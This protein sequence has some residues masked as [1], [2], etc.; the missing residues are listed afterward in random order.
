MPR[1][2]EVHRAICM[3]ISVNRPSAVRDC[4]PRS[5]MSAASSSASTLLWTNSVRTC[6][7]SKTVRARKGGSGSV[8][9]RICKRLIDCCQNVSR[10][11]CTSNTVANRK[12]PTR[13]ACAQSI[14]KLPDDISNVANTSS[15]KQF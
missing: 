8:S 3:T 10:R 7:D 15:F 5:R 4:W 11:N 14:T 1:V 2:T 13:K 9:M 12:K 6:N